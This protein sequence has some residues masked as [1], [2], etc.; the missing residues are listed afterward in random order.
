MSGLQYITVAVV[1]VIEIHVAT[2]IVASDTAIA[3]V[4]SVGDGRGGCTRVNNAMVRSFA[5]PLV[6][7]SV[8]VNMT[9]IVD[10]A[11]V[12]VAVV[13]RGKIMLR[14]QLQCCCWSFDIAVAAII[15]P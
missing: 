12:V 10:V 1:T 11:A 15:L 4:V 5:V 13:P 2:V 7:G 8:G 6:G 14:Q 3:T 9:G